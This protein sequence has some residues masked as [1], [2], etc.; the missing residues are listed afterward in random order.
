MKEKINTIAKKSISIFMALIMITSLFVMAIP[1]A[2]TCVG[3]GCP[4]GGGGCGR[5]TNPCGTPPTLMMPILPDTA[6]ATITTGTEILLKVDVTEPHDA[7]PSTIW[8]ISNST[9]SE[10]HHEVREGRIFDTWFEPRVRGLEIWFEALE[11]GNV[12]IT[13]RSVMSPNVSVNFNIQIISPQLESISITPEN[14]TV[15]V[16]EPIDF[17][18]IVNPPNADQRVTWTIDNATVG[19][20]NSNTGLFTATTPGT[21]FITATS[22]SNNNII[23]TS[24][25]I[26]NPALAIQYI[27]TLPYTI[28]TIGTY[29]LN[30]DSTNLAETAITINSDD[31]ILKGMGHTLDGTDAIDTHAINVIGNR[32]NVTIKN[33]T[34][35][36][37]HNGI[38]FENVNNGEIYNVN[39]NS[40]Y[41][42]I[43]LG[44]SNNHLR[45]NTMHNNRYNFYTSRVQ[46]IDTS[47]TVDGKP[48]I[49][50]VD[51]SDIIIDSESLAGVVYVVNSHNIT[52]KDL[53]LTNNAH[54]VSLINTTESKI[55][56]ITAN[57][58][59]WAVQLLN[60][61]NNMVTHV[62]SCSNNRSIFLEGIST[63]NNII[64]NNNFIN[65]VNHGMF[66]HDGAV[67]NKIYL[68][69]FI[70]NGRQNIWGTS[71]DLSANIFNS[72]E[73]I[74]YQFNSSIHTNYL[75]NHYD[76]YDGLDAGGDGIGDSSHDIRG[77]VAPEVL[78]DFPLMMPVENYEIV[79]GLRG[80]VNG[81]GNINAADVTYLDWHIRRFPG[82]DIIYTNGDINDDGN[83]NA[84]DVTYLD[85]HI[86][87]FPGFEVIH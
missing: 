59:G 62:T 9:V 81:D 54:A 5:C 63:T 82:F 27:T 64:R 20:I 73:A 78:V 1:M 57:L 29:I 35:T 46:N 32:N 69:N 31:V 77:G 34:V 19:T 48:I 30:I 53:V 8:V 23:A 38:R 26:V 66:I 84:A 51:A 52:V 47:N 61:S 79:D 37:W 4:G 58:N 28:H 17:D 25:V 13:A 55:E 40:N 50:L 42:G 87:R 12:T 85:W 2:I 67:N 6:T 83:I 80:D 72:S 24:K 76:N 68:N 65:S 70:N 21:A 14:E 49:F 45:S 22:V 3:G 10:E 56:N 75:G 86:R 16:G 39:A 60:S 18:V 44:G 71:E 7:N 43:W 41:Y 15:N 11:L 74:I 36:D 33:L